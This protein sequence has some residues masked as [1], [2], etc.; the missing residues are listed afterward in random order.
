MTR[1]RW[2]RVRLS[3]VL[4]L[5]AVACSAGA[6]E[7]PKDQLIDALRAMRADG[8]TVVDLSLAMDDAS[9]AALQADAED[10]LPPQAAQVIKSAVLRLS[11]PLT[12]DA[13]SAAVAFRVAEED[14]AEFRVIDKAV[15]VRADVPRLLETFGQDAGMADGFRQ[16]LSSG[17]MLPADAVDGRWI[18]LTGAEQAIKAFTDMG[19][20]QPPGDQT[21][22]PSF[23]PAKVQAAGTRLAG[24]IAEASAV[25]RV[26]SDADGDHLRVSVPLRDAYAAVMAEVDALGFPV[27]EDAR[28]SIEDIPDGNVVFDLWLKGGRI[29]A[30]EFD[31]LQVAA[32]DPE[33]DIPEGVTRLA[34]RAEFTPFD[35]VVATPADAVEIDVAALMQGMFMGMALGESMAGMGSTSQGFD[36]SM[37]P[38]GFDPGMMPPGFDPSMMPPG[39]AEPTRAPAP[40]G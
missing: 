6:P 9:L 15:Y 5:A 37:M 14:L 40:N 18:K 36:P 11:M 25:E 13:T 7:D 31:F 26:G 34:L 38:P 32:L 29:S 19:S 22:P 28:T 2:T 33:A 1:S 39:Y 27:A 12:A 21:S 3:M 24:V 23:D 20:A 35:G 10:P 17:G 16:M 4:T 30:A 8:G